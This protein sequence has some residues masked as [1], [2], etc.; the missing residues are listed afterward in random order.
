MEVL[1]I[2]C[3]GD[4]A[5]LALLKEPGVV[6]PTSHPR[7]LIPAAIPRAQALEEFVEQLAAAI[8]STSADRVALV[9]PT[10]GRGP[11]P[12]A[13]RDLKAAFAR[14]GMQVLVEVAAGRSSLPLELVTPQRIRGRLRPAKG[15]ELEAI[16]G[17]LFGSNPP[18]WAERKLAA[19]AAET[20]MR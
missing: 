14:G 20:L 4:G 7:L 12:Y 10:Y 11:R 2:R 16:A 15:V 18:Y 1:G 6:S 3:S 8:S 13:P 17:P 5:Y 19:L 9:Q